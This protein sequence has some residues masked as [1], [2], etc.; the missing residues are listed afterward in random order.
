M[1][2]Q[3]IILAATA[4]ISASALPTVTV[5]QTTFGLITIHSGSEV[6]NAGVQAA[7]GSLLVNAKSQNAS[8]DVETNFATFYIQDEELHLYAASATPQT[9]FVDRSGMGQGKIGYVTGAEPLGKNW[10]TVGWSVDETSGLV[11]DGTGLQACPGSIDGAWSLWLAG[12]DTPGFNQNCTGV[13]AREIE[14][15]EPISCVYTQ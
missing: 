10:E 9:I 1:L 12:V 7:R 6:Q 11:F 3:S 5:A 8:C 14:T 4:A 2:F 13:K 15:T